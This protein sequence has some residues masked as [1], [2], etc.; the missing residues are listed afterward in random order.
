MKTQS[1]MKCD[2]CGKHTYLLYAIPGP[3][4]LCP[5]CYAKHKEEKEQSDGV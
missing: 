4:L 1:D 3:T 5:E 2:R